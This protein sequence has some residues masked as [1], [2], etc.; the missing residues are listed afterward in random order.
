[1]K[2]NRVIITGGPSTGK[3]SLI[4][5]LENIGYN[6]VHETSREIIQESLAN[7]SDVLPWKNLL[8]F[9]ER[10]IQQR[11]NHYHSAVSKGSKKF[12]FFDRGIPDVF[13]YMEYDRIEIPKRF[14]KLGESLRY[15]TKIF[16][17]PAWKAIYENDNERVEDFNKAEQ[18]QHYIHNIYK[19]LGYEVI[20]IPKATIENRIRFILDHLDE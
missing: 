12:T 7:G 16:I 17:T 9:S 14:L 8:K 11:E 3:T 4:K 5:E 10:V 15:H 13:A 2:V 20:V 19:G 1:L 6:C 18:L